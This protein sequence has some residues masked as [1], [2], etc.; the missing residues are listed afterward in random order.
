[1]IPIKQFSASVAAT[2]ALEGIRVLSLEC[3]IAGPTASMW[4]ADMGAE[5]IKIEQP[6]SGDPA[7]LLEPSKDNGERR[8]LA[9]LRPNRNKKSL[10]LNLKQPEGAAL[11]EQLL[12]KS[13]VLID[14][15]RPDAL[16]RLGFTWERLHQINPQL[17]YTA[18]SGFGRKE[19]S[20]GPFQDW[21]AFDIVGQAMAGLMQRPERQTT[22][23]AY[24][25]FPL[26]DIQ[27]GIVAATG[28]LQ[29]LFQR[30][31]TGIGQ[32]IDIAMYDA[33][34]VMNELAIILNA[35]LGVV[36]APGLHA[37]SYPFGSFRAN[38]GFIVIAVLGEKIWE[39]FCVAIGR[40]EL[41]AD[42]RL[43]SGIDRNAHASWLNPL[44]N[45]WVGQRSRKH[46][47]DYLIAQG[48]PA[49]PVQDVDD[50]AVC[51]QVAARDM[52]LEIDDPA[53]GKVKV[54]GQPIKASGSPPARNAPPPKLG[55]HTDALLSELVGLDGAAMADLRSRGVV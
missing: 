46:S 11:F 10:T 14:N 47:V 4:L 12:K 43:Q 48:V 35:A 26:A 39:R 53:W 29:A 50:I 21:P 37:L 3:F 49:G 15:L 30:T 33:A 55:E 36:P 25:G 13:D 18:I 5:V 34:L 8:S 41:G 44:I 23:P 6:G 27:V 51:P 28:T 52:L 31:R 16:E 24:L 22:D 40:P 42:P 7:R 38:D 2:P 17:I 20:N 1:M 45:D 32:M 19:T 54:P 9:L